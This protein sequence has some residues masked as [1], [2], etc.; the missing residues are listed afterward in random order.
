LSN[1]YTGLWEYHSCPQ[2]DKLNYTADRQEDGDIAKKRILIVDDESLN[3]E[4]LT[5][6]LESDYTITS[7]LSGEEALELAQ[8]DP[9]PNL[10]LLDVSMP[11]IDG[12]ETCARLKAS[13]VTSMIPVVFL[14]AMDLEQ[15]EAIGFEVGAID[16]I[17][18]PIVPETVQARI[19]VHLIL[20][21]AQSEVR[22]YQKLVI[23]QNSELQRLIDVKRKLVHMLRVK[24]AKLVELT[25]K[26]EGT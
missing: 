19:R 23:S 7:A 26:L 24:D 3:I 17:S 9:K 2:I 14:T 12:Y 4:L 18:K 16:Y 22:R 1:R 8:C 20:E 21:Q 15:D 11:G 13:E 5:I 10:I 25:R 6:Y